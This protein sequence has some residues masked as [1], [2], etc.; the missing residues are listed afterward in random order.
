[1][2]DSWCE[3]SLHQIYLCTFLSWKKAFMMHCALLQLESSVIINVSITLPNA[4]IEVS[5]N[6]PGFVQFILF[7]GHHQFPLQF[8][9]TVHLSL[10]CM[11]ASKTGIGPIALAATCTPFFL[12]ASIHH[13]SLPA[14]DSA[15]Q[16]CWLNA[17]VEEF[18]STAQL[19]CG[20][21]TRFS[22]KNANN[23]QGILLGF[24]KQF[25]FFA[26]GQKNVPVSNY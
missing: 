6:D 9:C 12:V 25:V 17:A 15:S 2:S 19:N 1:M 24:L 16:P 8:L 21:T 5:Q 14:E 23:I 4:C 22:H 10:R 7:A 20:R 3:E 26:H 18:S 13:H 11:P